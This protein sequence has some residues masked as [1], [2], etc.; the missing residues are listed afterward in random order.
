MPGLA[1][2]AAA[3]QQMAG[4]AE[5]LSEVTLEVWWFVTAERCTSWLESNDA[6]NRSNS[7][8]AGAVMPV[9][10]YLHACQAGRLLQQLVP[11]G[12]VGTALSCSSCQLLSVQAV[13]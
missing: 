11:A 2:A 5:A 1:A 8:C 9:K 13:P 4:A 6:F 7:P 3:A 10:R 12:S